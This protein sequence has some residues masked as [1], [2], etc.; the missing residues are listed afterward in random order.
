MILK[1]NP[2]NIARPLN[3]QYSGRNNTSFIKTNPMPFDTVSFKGGEKHMTSRADAINYGLAQAIYNEAEP[4]MTD[5][6]SKLTKYFGPLVADDGHPDRVLSPYPKGLCV[7][8]K[9]PYSIC[10]KTASVG[11]STKAEIKE[12]LGDII[13]ARLVIRDASKADEVLKKVIEGVKNNDIKIFEIENYRPEP[14]YSYFTKKQ[15]DSLEKICN[16]MRTNGVTRTEKSIPSGYTALH[17]SAYLPNG[18]KGEIQ[19]LGI[20]VEKVKEIEDLLYKLKN[21]KSLP[22]HYKVIE[23]EFI[24]LKTNKPL[25]RAITAYSKEQYIAA[26]E[27]E[28]YPAK[29]KRPKK[30]LPAPNYVPPEYDFN[31]IWK[32]KTNC[33]YKK[34]KSCDFDFCQ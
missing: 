28:P 2:F 21:N 23:D 8:L 3:T 22:P 15:L 14:K 32:M 27:R 33:D 16:K 31:R 6:Q 18:F 17:L 34:A 12:Q 30:F 4:I 10:E 24:D 11:V 1:I 29:L 20:D 19:I 7:R 25:Q 13:G 9:T 5:F 26:R